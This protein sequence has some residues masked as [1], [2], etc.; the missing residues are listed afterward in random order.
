MT[1]QKD[2]RAEKTTAYLRGQMRFIEFVYNFLYSRVA[3]VDIMPLDSMSANRL[4]FVIVV[5]SVAGRPTIA[6]KAFP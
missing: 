4:E 2:K 6:F 5:T 1:R 3:F